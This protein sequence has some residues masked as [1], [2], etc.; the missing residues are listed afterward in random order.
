M[1]GPTQCLNTCTPSHFAVVI[2]VLTTV[3]I[4]CTF[5]EWGNMNVNVIKNQVLTRK[6][7]N[8]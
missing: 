7:M 2:V 1:I 4:L 5:N 3:V 6:Q 8:D